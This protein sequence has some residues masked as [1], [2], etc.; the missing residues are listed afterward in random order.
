MLSYK[1]VLIVGRPNVGKSA[2][3][4]RILDTKE[5]LLRVLTVLLEI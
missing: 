2:L 5:V 4:N 3:F 1:K